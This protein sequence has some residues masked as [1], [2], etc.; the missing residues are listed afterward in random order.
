MTAACRLVG[1]LV[2]AAVLLASCGD[3]PALTD[4]FESDGASWTPPYPDSDAGA[5]PD[6]TPSGGAPP[7]YFARQCQWDACGG[8]LPTRG[9]A[10]PEDR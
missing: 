4:G 9:P 10:D 2:T 8:P 3:A 6:E 5:S 1:A 7:G